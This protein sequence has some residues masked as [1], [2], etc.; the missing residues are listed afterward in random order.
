M[1]QQPY[2]LS[3][4]LRLLSC[5]HTLCA[6]CLRILYDI[7]CVIECLVCGGEEY[8]EDID[9]IPVI[10]AVSSP[11][12]PADLQSQLSG[13]G[14]EETNEFAP[15]APVI[16]GNEDDGGVPW[17]SCLTHTGPKLWWCTVC[18]QDLCDR[19]HQYHQRLGHQ[20]VHHAEARRLCLSRHSQESQPFLERLSKIEKN[21]RRTL[22]VAE[23]VLP[24]LRQTLSVANNH[25]NR[26]ATQKRD[27][28][29]ASSPGNMVEL[30]Q[31]ASH[32]RESSQPS[33]EQQ[34]EAVVESL[35]SLTSSMGDFRQEAKVKPVE[36][37][38]DA[39]SLGQV[40]PK[41]K[42]QETKDR[43]V[44]GSTGRD[45]SFKTE[46]VERESCVIAEPEVC[47][48]LQLPFQGSVCVNLPESAFEFYT[49][50]LELRVP[51]NS[52]SWPWF[53]LI[54]TTSDGSPIFTTRCLFGND[55]V[56]M[57][58]QA[59]KYKGPVTKKKKCRLR[60]GVRQTLTVKE[61]EK[62]YEVEVNGD[63]IAS[64]KKMIQE[65]PA[66]IEVRNHSM[67]SDRSTQ[68]TLEVISF[69]VMRNDASK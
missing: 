12:I 27:L 58:A 22:E 29:N 44:T 64:I 5:G 35:Q 42:T 16:E 39:G 38:A 54:F 40:V 52:G 20:T 28:E 51:N 32:W 48:P 59:K 11:E 55:R 9:E 41:Y 4:C 26:V 53:E 57:W 31:E 23:S 1:C 15:S 37:A 46:E 62:E 50:H 36:A 18:Y 2:D 49:A 60:E 13:L 24:L 65:V 17:E 7:N 21:T 6:P 66:T 10:F 3:S 63:R 33:T 67:A 8:F 25:I 43:A 45:V 19:C 14:L 47:L 61:Y 34:I 56:L 30:L 68:P 69:R